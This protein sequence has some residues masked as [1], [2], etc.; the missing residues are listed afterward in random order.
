M[1][2]NYKFSLRIGEI[3]ISLEGSAEFI[4]EHYKIIKDDMIA[5]LE[6]LKKIPKPTVD[7]SKKESETVSTEDNLE[8]ELPE[9]FGEWLTRVPK[10]I[11]DTDKALLAGYFHQINSENNVFKVR[12]LTKT[13]KDHGIKLSNPSNLIKHAA[14]SKKFIFQQSKEGNQINYRFSREGEEYIQSLLK[15]SS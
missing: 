5:Y 13:L 14:K 3:E 11:S 6:L 4:S 15:T 7:I 12:D 9:T 10:E 8:N 1:E 2:N